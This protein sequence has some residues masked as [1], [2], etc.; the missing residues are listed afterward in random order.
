MR[1]RYH[2][3]HTKHARYNPNDVFV[4]LPENQRECQ[5]SQLIG[6]YTPIGQHSEADLNWIISNCIE[7]SKEKYLEVSEGF[8]T[9]EEY[10]KTF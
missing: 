7:I 5:N 1:N 3:Y 10:L 8:Y 4:L 6:I 9:P 2:Y